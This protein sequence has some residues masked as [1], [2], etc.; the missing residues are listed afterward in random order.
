MFLLEPLDIRIYNR[1]Y[2]FTK[3]PSRYS[4]IVFFSIN[5]FGRLIYP[6]NILHELQE[7]HKIA[8]RYFKIFTI[9][10]RTNDYTIII[11]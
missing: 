11:K 7:L 5:C 1:L 6:L 2:R 4:A 3:S 8:K 10:E 9:D